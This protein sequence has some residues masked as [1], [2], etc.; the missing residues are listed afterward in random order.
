MISTRKWELRTADTYLKTLRPLIKPKPNFLRQLVEFQTRIQQTQHNNDATKDDN[1]GGIINSNPPSDFH[2]TKATIQSV[3]SSS[4]VSPFLS[5]SP[6]VP[7]SSS[8][9][10]FSDKSNENKECNNSNNDI[11]S[12]DKKISNIIL[13]SEINNSNCTTN[14]NNHY[15]NESSSN[16]IHHHNAN[17]NNH[18][19]EIKLATNSKKRKFDEMTANS[20]GY[21]SNNEFSEK[22]LKSE[23]I[24]NN[25]KLI[26]IQNN[27]NYH[28]NHIN[29]TKI[30]IKQAKCNKRV[31]GV[32]L[33]PHLTQNQ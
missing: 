22:R 31:Y 21:P 16:H 32:S 13:I 5:P 9:S 1:N 18:K 19:N 30:L 10:P 12:N 6:S 3:S 28:T 27:D 23:E 4:F 7:P 15:A 24:E 25:T 2:T 11:N 14:N 17:G 20:N 33:P 8:I 26:S 29:S